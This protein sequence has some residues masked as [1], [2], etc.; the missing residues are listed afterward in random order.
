MDERDTYTAVGEG[1][2]VLGSDNGRAGGNESNGVL[3]V[4]EVGVLD[5]WRWEG[6]RAMETLMLE[7]GE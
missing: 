2:D 1:S 7:V 4:D 6:G 5:G 3:H